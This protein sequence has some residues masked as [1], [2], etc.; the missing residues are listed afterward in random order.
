MG[1]AQIAEQ[2]VRLGQGQHHGPV[3]HFHLG[4]IGQL[5]AVKGAGAGGLDAGAAASR[6]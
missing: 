5:A 2:R 3:A 4:H 1:C 6:R